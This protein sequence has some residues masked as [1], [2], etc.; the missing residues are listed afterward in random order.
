MTGSA[1]VIREFN[2]KWEPDYLIKTTETLQAVTDRRN[3][4]LEKNAKGVCDCQTAA[5][6]E[7]ATR[8]VEVMT[9]KRANLRTEM[10]RR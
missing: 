9:M 10:R 4:A 1:H 3:A 5:D 7:E 2:K 8:E 6:V